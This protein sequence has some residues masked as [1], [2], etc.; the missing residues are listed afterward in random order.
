MRRSS[1]TLRFRDP[2]RL[3]QPGL[4]IRRR[5]PFHHLQLQPQQQQRLPG[6][7]MQFPAEPAALLF[8]RAPGLGSPAAATPLCSR[9]P[10]RQ[11]AC[12][13]RQIARQPRDMPGRQTRIES[14]P[15]GAR[16]KTSSRRVARAS[17]GRGPAVP[18]GPVVRA[19]PAFPFGRE[20]SRS[21][22]AAR[23]GMKRAGQNLNH[24]PQQVVQAARLGL[25][26]VRVRRM[27]ALQLSRT[28]K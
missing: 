3:R 4:Q 8:F 18:P 11:R 17:Q 5:V 6:L 10:F 28:W 24:S 16:D 27:P 20:I 21:T 14:P 7:I 15:R 13:N 1:D 22:S 12:N 9:A 25:R 23:A 19:G 26:A 2:A